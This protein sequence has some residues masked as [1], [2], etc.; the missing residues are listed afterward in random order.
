ML[1]DVRLVVWIIGAIALLAL[2]WDGLKRHH[3]SRKWLE[4]RKEQ[5]ELQRREQVAA[6]AEKRSTEQAIEAEENLSH[7]SETKSESVTSNIIGS[8]IEEPEVLTK[9][10]G[11]LIEGNNKDEISGVSENQEDKTE[12]QSETINTN[13]LDE[14]EVEPI[15][16]TLKSNEKYPFAGFRL[17]HILLKKGFHFNSE[18]H[19]FDYYLS[20]DMQQPVLFSLVAATK[21]GQFDITNMANFSCKG[22]IVF[23]E[24]NHVIDPIKSFEEMVAVAEELANELMAEMF[25]KQDQPWD[26]IHL[27]QLREICEK[28]SFK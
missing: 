14:H 15:L 5:Q 28:V 26:D 11:I 9:E 2:L 23:F 20:Q 21:T 4:K 16:F 12:P 18:K 17:L 6:E 22:L 13:A 19:W 24:P 3:D 27:V 1:N 7:P 10:Q 25:I 8:T